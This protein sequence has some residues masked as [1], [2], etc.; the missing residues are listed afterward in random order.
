MT[1]PIHINVAGVIERN[2]RFLMVEETSSGKLVLNQPAGHLEANESLE[3]GVIREVK[4]ESAWT[5]DPQHLI[6]IYSWRNPVKNHVIIRFA[7]SG[8]CHDHDPHQALDSGIERTLWLSVEELQE[9]EARLRNPMV[10]RC[11]SDYLNDKRYPLD[12]VQDLDLET[13][14]KYAVA[15]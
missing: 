1:S 6:G 4:E 9:N 2:G 3:Q 10:L 13:A 15:V 14:L 8:T 5:F 12:V 11:I 7:Y